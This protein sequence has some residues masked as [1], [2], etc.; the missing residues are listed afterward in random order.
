MVSNRGV[1]VVHFDVNL[2]GRSMELE[3]KYEFLSH[4]TEREDAAKQYI[5]EF[6]KNSTKPLVLKVSFNDVPDESATAEKYFRSKF[7]ILNVSNSVENLTKRVGFFRKK[8]TFQIVNQLMY[9]GDVEI[10]YENMLKISSA[11]YDVILALEAGV[12]VEVAV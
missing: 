11:Q 4:E 10:S 9:L 6:G 1:Q 12:S 5:S 2:G 3:L 8:V 7:N